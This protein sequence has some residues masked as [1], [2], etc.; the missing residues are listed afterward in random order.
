[1]TDV[2]A[3][4]FVDVHAST[5]RLT[6]FLDGNRFLIVSTVSEYSLRQMLLKVLADGSLSSPRNALNDRHS[7]R[8]DIAFH[9][10]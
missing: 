4:L 8:S 3:N 10:L 9:A 2:I 1:M 6:L 7:A 5:G